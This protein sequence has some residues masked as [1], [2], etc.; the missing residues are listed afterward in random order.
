MHIRNEEEEY[1]RAFDTP[2]ITL[3]CGRKFPVLSTVGSKSIIL[4]SLALTDPT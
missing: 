3:P 1:V 4:D 2:S